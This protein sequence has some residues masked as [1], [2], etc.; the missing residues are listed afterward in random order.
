MMAKIFVPETEVPET[1]GT[2]KLEIERT[3][4]NVIDAAGRGTGEGLALALNVG[5]MLISFLALVALVNF[6]LGL[7]GLSLQQIFGWVFAPIAWS[8]GV[9]WR[10]RAG[11]RQPARDAHGA[12]RV[13]GLLAARPAEGRRSIPAR[14]PS[15]RSRCAASR[16]SARSASRSAASAR[17]RR[18]AGTTW[19]ASGCARCWPARS[20]TSSPRR[21][22]GSCCERA[23]LRSRRSQQAVECA[24][25]R[26]I[27]EVPDV[28]VVLGSGL[29][30]FAPGFDDDDDDPVRRDSRTGRPRRWS[31]MPARWWS[32][33]LGR[34]ARRRAERG[35]R[36]STRGTTSGR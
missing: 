2:V 1:M 26:G 15:R 16:T 12:Q 23:R 4:V 6:L 28:A 33:A 24:A 8:M 9:P 20:P 31:A 5:A 7:V 29:G 22:R 11:D 3:D 30:D 27:G 36:T 35:G 32:A 14:S 21:S 18:R 10:G 17:S 34:E 25:R 19:R 13:R